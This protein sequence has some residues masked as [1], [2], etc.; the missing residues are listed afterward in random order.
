MKF[1][2]QALLLSMFAS[3]GAALA[4]HPR[5]GSHY[6][7][8]HEWARYYADTAIHQVHQSRYQHCGYH[9]QRWSG[10]YRDHYHWA[11]RVSRGQA[12][13]EINRR[14]RDL[15]YCFHHRSG[16]HGYRDHGHHGRGGHH[17]GH[18]YDRFDRRRH[19][20]N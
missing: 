5:Y 15:R 4:D 2:L 13:S 11:L 7:A 6:L 8:Q 19:G 18:T 12:R 1:M 9:G 20:R 17:P 14:D 16:Y 3:S 10:D